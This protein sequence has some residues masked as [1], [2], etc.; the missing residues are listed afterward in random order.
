MIT[1]KEEGIHL[2]RV[3]HYDIKHSSVLWLNSLLRIR[4]R[5]IKSDQQLKQ[6][7]V[8]KDTG[9]SVLMERTATFAI[10]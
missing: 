10:L 5:T 8:W 9:V 7:K 3:G 1:A 2:I 6:I 4:K